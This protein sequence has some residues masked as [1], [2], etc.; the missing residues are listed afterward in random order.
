MANFLLRPANEGDTEQLIKIWCEAFG[1]NEAFVRDMLHDCGL[2][3]KAVGAEM[4]GAL[5]SVIFRFEDL[6]CGGLPAAYLY[7]LC[8]QSEYRGL[9]MG[10]AVT[11]YG[12]KCALERGAKNVF[13]RPG[14]S[15]LEKWYCEELS[16]RVVS[17]SDEDIFRPSFPAVEKARELSPQEYMRLRPDSFWSVGKDIIQA[18]GLINRYCGGSFLA[19]GGSIL[20]AVEN[21]GCVTVHELFSP[22]PEEALSAAAEFFSVPALHILRPCADGTALLALPGSEILKT[23][24]EIPPL[25]FTLD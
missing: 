6:R 9:G 22:H 19:V 8:T 16:A 17:R 13:L 5:R 11:E 7:A 20:C 1:D 24:G 2:I 3:E 21:W 10:R 15:S 25:P 14:E 12:T 18:Q 4:D 23:G